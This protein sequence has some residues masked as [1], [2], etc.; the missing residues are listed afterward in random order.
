MDEIFSP[1][2]IELPPTSNLNDVLEERVGAGADKPMMEVPAGKG[3][4]WRV[5][6][7]G[8]FDAE[9]VAVAKGLVARGIEPGDKVG[10]M[11]RTR[12]EWAVLDFAA[13]AA[14]AVPVP[15]YETSSAEQVEWILSDADVKLV[16]TETPANAATV[17]EVREACPL[18]TDVLV[19]DD[20]AL[21]VLTADG[22]DVPD[23]EITRRR[24]LADLDDLATIIY[25]SGTTGRPKG[26]EL[27]HRNFASLAVNAVE[28]VPEVFAKDGG[29]TLLFI[30]MAH[31]FARYIHVLGVAGGVV[32]GHWADTTTLVD[33]LG[34]FKPTFILAVPRVF[35]KVYNTAEQTAAAGGKAKIFHWATAT[36]I[37]WSRA[38]DTPSGPSLGLK[39]Q[40]SVASALVYSK[41]RAKLGGRAEF[42]VSG[43]GPLGERLGHFYRGLGLKVLEGYGLTES[44][45][46]TS[47]NRPTATKIGS[48]GPQLP[49]CAAKIAADGEILLKGHHI[50]KGYHKNEA[51]TAES[52]TE[53]GWFRTGDLGVL[54]D[55]GFLT[56]TGRKKE[57]IVTAGGKNVAPSNLEDRIRSHALVSQCV[58]VGDNKPFIG[59]LITLDA[60]GL[61]GWLK[62]HGKPALSV[63]EARKDPDVLAA[64]DEA[65]RRANKAVSKAESI[66]KYTVLAGDLTIENG[67]LTPKQSVKRSVFLKDFDADVERLY[68]DKNKESLHLIG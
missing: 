34:E 31:V 21:D 55:D 68:A 2:L 39:L 50:F 8:Q 43:G 18:V 33:G 23:A 65:V 52:F 64:L 16:F 54:D 1:I 30:P 14:G 53:D 29:R 22:A 11:C 49:G 12:Y 58:V 35:E 46:P 44:T 6:T 61:P 57:I 36:G 10:I 63:D 7:A 4:P 42:A 51:A 24:A 37:A 13:W 56:I 45:A 19:I 32:T 17:E 41:L 60:E 20:G 66:R 27:T 15:V 38:L 5:V 26:A 67:Y 25:T 48:V 3:E 62:M 59:A 47:V 40:H 28:A 9:V